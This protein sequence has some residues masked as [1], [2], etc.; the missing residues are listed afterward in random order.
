MDIRWMVFVSALAAAGCQD[1]GTTPPTISVDGGAGGGGGGGGGQACDGPLGSPILDFSGMEACCSDEN[2]TYGEG[3]CLEG[4]SVPTEL[5]EYLDTCASG[6]VCVPDQFLSTGGAVP[7]TTCTAFGGDGV[8][9]SQCVP[10]VYEQAALLQPDVCS[11]DQL[12]VPCI[13]PLDNMP[14]GACDL[15]ELTTCEAGSGG[16]GGNPPPSGCDDPNTCVYEANCPALIEPS[17]LPE[18]A[19]DA[20]CLSSGLVPAEMAA[21]LATC[22]GGTDLC[23]PDDFIR[24]GGKFLPATCSSAGGAE[25]RCLSEALPAVAEQK[26]LLPQDICAPTER[27][28]PC[29][30]P[31][32]GSDT[33]A[34]RLACDEGPQAAP[35]T[36]ASC[37]EGK[38]VCVPTASVPEDQQGQLGEQECEDLTGADDLCVPNEI[39]AGG[40]FPACTASG[41]LTGDYTGVCLADCLEYGI[42]GLAVKQGSCAD[43]YRCAPCVN[44]LSGEP[45][46]APG[47]PATP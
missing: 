12:C 9:L 22:G 40:P 10:A 45:T 41:L 14:T 36:F 32:D 25:G 7:P 13:S 44:P 26:D 46:G 33:G 6:G 38:A 34:C 18:C 20:H 2:G 5:G 47:C 31:L 28:S 42:Q 43:D 21:Q 16:G 29:F 4:D 17:T 23:V 19:A 11:G 3:H 27:C 24:T 35:V 8:C 1:L 30:N 15:R 39:V 37:C